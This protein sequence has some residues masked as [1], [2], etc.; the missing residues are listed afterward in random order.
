M[1]Y[2][3]PLHLIDG[4]KFLLN[5]SKLIQSFARCK[6]FRVAFDGQLDSFWNRYIFMVHCILQRSRQS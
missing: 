6:C 3:H 2:L 4:N 1:E 5:S